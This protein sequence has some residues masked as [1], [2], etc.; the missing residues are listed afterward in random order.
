MNNANAALASQFQPNIGRLVQLSID[1]QDFLTLNH[2][3][4]DATPLGER[5]ILSV[6]VNEVDIPLRDRVAQILGRPSGANAYTI[7]N[8]PAQPVPEYGAETTGLFHFGADNG[9]NRFGGGNRAYLL[10]A[11][12]FYKI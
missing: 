8:F 3:K 2:T 7:H 6:P 10:Y 5:R 11:V 9:V 1:G 4:V 12:Q